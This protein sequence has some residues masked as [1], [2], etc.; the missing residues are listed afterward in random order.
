MIINVCVLCGIRRA[1][2]Q[3]WSLTHTYDY[4]C[5][6]VMWNQTRLEPDPYIWLYMCVCYVESGE[7]WCKTGAWPIRRPAARQ[8]PTT[9][10]GE[11]VGNEPNLGGTVWVSVWRSVAAGAQCYGLS[12]CSFYILFL[13]ISIVFC[14]SNSVRLCCALI[15]LTLK[16]DGL[17]TKSNK[18]LITVM[19][20]HLW[21]S[22]LCI[23]TDL[24][25]LSERIH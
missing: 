20:W 22:C 2:M 6:C 7:R 3:D 24:F 1:Q 18:S 16:A 17:F 8:Q 10:D 15:S 12:C 19:Y 14:D 25:T 5:V 23:N 13:N 4:I 11:K 9:D 21:H